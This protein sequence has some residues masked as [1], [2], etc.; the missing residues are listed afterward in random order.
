MNGNESGVAVLPTSAIPVSAAL[1]GAR[2]RP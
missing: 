2:S 1:I